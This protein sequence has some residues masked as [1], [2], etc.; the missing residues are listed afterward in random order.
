MPPK[1]DK[2]GR[3][4]KAVTAQR[5]RRT[6]GNQKQTK[7][8]TSPATSPPDSPS[9]HTRGRRQAAARA[10]EKNVDGA[11]DMEQ[12]EALGAEAWTRRW[13]LPSAV[14]TAADWC[15]L[16]VCGMLDV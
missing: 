1:R 16:F 7:K 15:F 11:H 4:V 3:K 13:Q 9:K 12:L 6:A 10:L 8:A 5:A 14:L 2:M